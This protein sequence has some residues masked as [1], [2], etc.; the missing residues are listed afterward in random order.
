M[1]NV[2]IRHHEHIIVSC[3]IVTVIAGSSTTSNNYWTTD[4]IFM[5]DSEWRVV[6]LWYMVLFHNLTRTPSVDNY[7]PF[8]NVSWTRF[9]M[10][11]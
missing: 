10:H 2:I 6:N 8:V 4:Y 5:V 9:Y 11:V 7:R 3:L 1:L